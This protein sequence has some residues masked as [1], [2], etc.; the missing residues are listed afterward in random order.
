MRNAIETARKRLVAAKKQHDWSKFVTWL[1]LPSPINLAGF[2]D[3]V[4]GKT[5]KEKIFQYCPCNDPMIR[6]QGWVVIERGR[7]ERERD[8]RLCRFLAIPLEMTWNGA[9]K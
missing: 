5:R 1:D 9:K 2:V 7:K 3:P 8:R 6:T 4:S